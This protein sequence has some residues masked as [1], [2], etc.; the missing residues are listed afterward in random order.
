MDGSRKCEG[1]PAADEAALC[2]LLEGDGCQLVDGGREGGSK[3]RR[4]G[5]E[6]ACCRGCAVVMCSLSSYV[7]HLFFFL[8]SSFTF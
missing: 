8:S 3:E 5:V 7:S 1:R 4:E 2:V 6:A